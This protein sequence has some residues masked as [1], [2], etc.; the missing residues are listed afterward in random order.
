MIS[1][2]MTADS[3]EDIVFAHPTLS[4]AIMESLEDLRDRSIHKI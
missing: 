2:N 3:V 4:E 1:N